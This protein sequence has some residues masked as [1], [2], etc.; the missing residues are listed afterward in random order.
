MTGALSANQELS[1]RLLCQGVALLVRVAEVDHLFDIEIDPHLIN[2]VVDVEKPLPANPEGVAKLAATLK[3]LVKPD[4]PQPVAA[5]PETAKAIS[6]KTFAFE[7]NE[8][9]LKIVRE[10]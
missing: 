4:S 9:N 1:V 10:G 3:D 2:A 7:Q 5:L 8:V 6:G